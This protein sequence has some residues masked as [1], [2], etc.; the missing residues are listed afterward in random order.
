MKTILPLLAA[1][2]LAAG[3]SK[4]V[5]YVHYEDPTGFSA[6]VPAKWPRL[7]DPDL[8]HKPSAMMEWVGVDAPQY[9]GEILGAVIHV[10]RISR[11][12]EDVPP[13]LSWEKYSADFLAPAEKI[14]ANQSGDTAEA[15]KETTL[16]DRSPF[17]TLA[18]TAI[19]TDLVVLRTP[20][21]YWV[22]NYTATK[23]NF[24]KYAPAFERLKA[25]AKPGR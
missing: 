2:L 21:A 14:F 8:T 19:K 9:A 20:D 11:K 22:L 18:P 24:D 12:R 3:C 16:Q 15:T 5:E 1:V 6:D 23:E 7:K 4:K 13:K 25:T 10:S 17:H